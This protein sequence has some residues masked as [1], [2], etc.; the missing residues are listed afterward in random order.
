MTPGISKDST[1]TPLQYLYRDL[2]L[3]S[4]TPS[5]DIARCIV[6]FVMTFLFRQTPELHHLSVGAHQ[7]RAVCCFE[8]IQSAFTHVKTGKDMFG[9]ERFVTAIKK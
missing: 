7:T 4:V 8:A 6:L 1:T 3:Q 5:R 2:P 9:V